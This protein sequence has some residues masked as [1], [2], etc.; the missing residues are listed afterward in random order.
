MV[1]SSTICSCGETDNLNHWLGHCPARTS[2]QEPH[3]ST[4]AHILHTLSWQPPPVP[5]RPYG[6][7]KCFI[8][9]ESVCPGTFTWHP[10]SPI[11]TD[12]SC[13]FANIRILAV[14]SCAAV[15]IEPV[16]RTIQY[17][18]PECF[19][20]SA[21][22]SEHV[23]VVLAVG[24][25]IAGDTA[26][27]VSDCQAVVSG[28][29]HPDHIRLGYRNPMGGFWAD[30]GCKVGNITKV[31]AHL[32][33]AAA[34]LG[35]EGHHHHGNYVVD[36]LA[37]AALPQYNHVDIECYLKGLGPKFLNLC[38]LSRRL[39]VLSGR[40]NFKS[41]TRMKGARIAGGR[42]ARTPHNYRWCGGLARFICMDCGKCLRNREG[43]RDRACPGSSKILDEAHLSHIMLR[44]RVLGSEAHLFFCCKCGCYTVSRSA[45][46]TKPCTRSPYHSTIHN[47]L[48]AS[49]HPVTKQPLGPP[50]RVLS[51]MV[52]GLLGKSFDSNGHALGSEGTSLVHLSQGG[53]RPDPRAEEQL[54][55]R[56][57]PADLQAFQAEW[58]IEDENTFAFGF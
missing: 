57:G 7:P 46:L 50:T 41:L 33:K 17:S 55:I 23:A 43:I 35:G 30:I 45:G 24:K 51:A 27:I 20:Q 8:D 49:T 26:D 4:R 54:S 19:P 36:I 37:K 2:H 39:S 42:P 6:Q 31:K 22:A 10:G 3:S 40:I 25:L 53:N 12:G 18:L 47:R 5:S 48:M 14:A 11:Y 38:L 15:Q 29:H 13:L 34:T 56:P 16:L 58:A 21:V 1:G 44:T 32:S 52:L 28:V 9:G